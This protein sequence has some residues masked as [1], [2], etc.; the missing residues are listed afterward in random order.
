MMK[1]TQEEYYTAPDQEI[2]DDIK[3][4][5]IEVWQTMDNTY[6]YVDEKVDR[7]KDI[8]NIKDNA[9]YMVA[10]FDQDNQRKLYA[11]AKPET[12]LLLNKLI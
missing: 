3:K 10:M 9:W 1:M 12:R 6:G 4:C 8:E 7:I 11:L 2:F 5:A